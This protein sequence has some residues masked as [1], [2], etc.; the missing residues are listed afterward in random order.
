[1]WGN[2]LP[3]QPTKPGGPDRVNTVEVIDVDGLAAG[4]W[5]LTVVGAN[6]PTGSQ[7]FALVA[8]GRAIS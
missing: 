8:R 5:V 6:V 4:T 1:V 2:H 3:G 7:P